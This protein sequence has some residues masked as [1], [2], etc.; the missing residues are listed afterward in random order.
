M[1]YAS[2]VFC[3][4]MRYP[5][6]T[7]VARAS[8]SQE[9]PVRS[10]SP[11]VF[12]EVTKTWEVAS[13]Q[14]QPKSRC[15]SADIYSI[16]PTSHCRE[17]SGATF[18]FETTIGGFFTPASNPG[19]ASFWHFKNCLQFEAFHKLTIFGAEGK[20][21]VPKDRRTSEANGCPKTEP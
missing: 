2:M 20:L 7:G 5:K 21:A 18:V 19:G 8:A 1:L 15:A 10:P 12:T 9:A 16:R 11:G 4:P 3:L 14:V 6:P 17:N 13:A